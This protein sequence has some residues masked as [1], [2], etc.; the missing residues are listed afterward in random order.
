MESGSRRN[1]DE[2]GL[3]KA[4]E[5]TQKDSITFALNGIRS[6]TEAKR[7][8]GLSELDRIFVKN[9]RSPERHRLRDGSYLW[10][11]QELFQDVRKE[12]SK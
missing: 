4:R 1:Q 6:G 8:E 10:L 5:Q 7:K 9:S 11:L 2:K 12:K 3:E